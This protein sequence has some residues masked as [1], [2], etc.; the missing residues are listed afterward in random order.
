MSRL[1]G[2]RLAAAFGSELL[3][4][5]VLEVLALDMVALLARSRTSGG[6]F[7]KCWEAASDGAAP[8]QLLRVRLS[9][10]GVFELAGLAADI[11][12]LGRYGPAPRADTEWAPAGFQADLLAGIAIRVS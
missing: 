10:N 3:Q 9:G 4:D 6:G 8:S 7:A 12:T 5:N 2:L 1:P 11:R